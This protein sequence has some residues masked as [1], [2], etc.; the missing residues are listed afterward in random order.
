MEAV[1]SSATQMYSVI[2][3][4]Y[5]SLCYGQSEMRYYCVKDT[6]VHLEVSAGFE[7]FAIEWEM[8]GYFG[9]APYHGLFS[10][11]GIT[12]SNTGEDDDQVPLEVSSCEFICQQGY[13]TVIT[14]IRDQDDEDVIGAEGGWEGAYYSILSMDGKK[15]LVGGTLSTGFTRNHTICLPEGEYLFIFDRSSSTLAPRKII[16]EICSVVLVGT[17]ESIY[18]VVD[19][20]YN[21]VGSVVATS[22][23]DLTP[24]KQ[25]SGIGTC[26]PRE[27][28]TLPFLMY[29]DILSDHGAR[30]A[31]MLLQLTKIGGFSSGDPSDVVYQEVLDFGMTGDICLADGCYDMDLVQYTQAQSS[32]SGAIGSLVPN[33]LGDNAIWNSTLGIAWHLCGFK[34]GSVPFHGH[35]CVERRY[36][37][38]YGLSGCPILK[39]YVHSSDRSL[40]IFTSSVPD[41]VVSNHHLHFI[42][43]AVPLHGVS[44]LCELEDGCYEVFLGGGERNYANSSEQFHL[45]GIRSD[46]PATLTLCLSDSGSKCAVSNIVHKHCHNMSLIGNTPSRTFEHSFIKIDTYG[47]GWG[48]SRYKIRSLPTGPSNSSKSV[49][50]EGKKIAE[51]TLSDG[52]YGIDHLC[53]MEACYMLYITPSDDSNEIAWWLCGRF[54]NA[55]DALYDQHLHFCVDKNGNCQFLENSDS[56]NTVDD[57]D[58]VTDDD[59]PNVDEN[60]YLTTDLPTSSPTSAPTRVGQTFA[61]SS[62]PTIITSQPTYAPSP[63]PTAFDW[64]RFGPSTVA[65]IRLLIDL[66]SSVPSDELNIAYLTT[67]IGFSVQKLLETVLSNYSVATNSNTPANICGIEVKI[68]STTIGTRSSGSSSIGSR[69]RES[70]NGHSDLEF[71]VSPSP[72][73]FPNIYTDMHATSV[74][75]LKHMITSS[76]IATMDTAYSDVRVLPSSERTYNCEVTIQLISRLS[77]NSDRV[78]NYLESV[79]DLQLQQHVVANIMQYSYDNRDYEYYFDRVYYFMDRDGNTIDLINFRMELL[80]VSEFISLPPH[81]QLTFAMPGANRSV[82]DYDHLHFPSLRGVYNTIISSTMSNPEN[83]DE[84]SGV[85]GTQTLWLY[86]VGQPWL[87]GGAV[88]VMILLCVAMLFYGYSGCKHLGGNATNKHVRLKVEDSLQEFEMINAHINSSATGSGSDSDV[89]VELKESAEKNSLTKMTKVKEDDA[90]TYNVL[91]PRVDT[92]DS[93]DRTAGLELEEEELRGEDPVEGN[94]SSD[95]VDVEDGTTKGG[96]GVGFGGVRGLLSNAARNTKKTISDLKPSIGKQ[97]K[98]DRV[99]DFDGENEV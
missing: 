43:D 63:G 79:E 99:A 16:S 51:G 68:S 92:T 28:T 46:L 25:L 45:C 22:S 31:S 2:D 82:A 20:H 87:L 21:C 34:S 44:E 49:A 52:G 88:V 27:V 29:D 67:S 62:L 12:V 24:N 57:F 59:F 3:D 32:G 94:Q 75:R 15:R 35:V 19:S 36:D 86:L 14:L 81:H 4:A 80:N 73:A 77:N 56:R 91:R 41:P 78:S 30:N 65:N 71:D 9:G 53:L 84:S 83:D 10:V 7:P 89:E 1:N 64:H 66:R 90:Y 8:C 95:K 96:G 97:N 76:S 72:T 37:M 17:Q 42:A 55:V 50:Y 74:D 61:P 38:C 33:P 40:A 39:T 6:V 11:S 58:T 54:G 70:V 93:A 85:Y 60:G 5:D 18:L 48:E 98:Y 69:R 47:D 26:G 23:S 13:E